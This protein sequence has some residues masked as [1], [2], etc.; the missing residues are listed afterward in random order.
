[1]AIGFGNVTP[2]PGY[3]YVDEISHKEILFSTAGLTQQ[4]V[5]LAASQGVLAAGTALGMVTATGLWKAY[6]NAASDGTQTCRGFL[7]DNVDTSDGYSYVA[8]I[9]VAG[10]L[11]N[12][13]LV[14]VDSYAVADLNARQDTVLDI[15]QF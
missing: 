4:G 2:A 14:G 1:M 7:R 9:V 10:M 15:F 3:S 13:K 11:V 5:T 8:N 12:S 6:S